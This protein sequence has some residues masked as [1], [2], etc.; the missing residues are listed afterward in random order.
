M[1]KRKLGRTDLHVS[2]LCLSAAHFG[3]GRDEAA[4]ALLDGYHAAGGGFV[5]CLG[6][7]ATAPGAPA[8]EG[9][10][11]DVVG[12]WRETR[13]VS[14]DSLVLASRVSFSRPAHGGTFALVNLV[15]ESCERSLRQLRTRHLDLLVCDWDEG[16][17]PVEDVLEAADMLIRAGLLRYAVAGAFP[18]WRLVDSLHRSATRHQPRF[19]ALQAEYSLLGRGPGER[20]ALAMCREHRL[21][22]LARSPLAGGFLGQRPGTGRDLLHPDRHWQ[23]E[24][25]GSHAG[26]AV[27][28]VLSEMADQRGV[29]PA[30]LAV[31]WVL[32]NAQVSSAVISPS[33]APEL[34]EL[35]G[36]SAFALAPEETAALAN[37]TTVQDSRMEL[38]H[39]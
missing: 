23:S 20:E 14:R 19:E 11:E 35:L 30:P 34:R 21:G 37:A 17:V 22:F 27:L 8:P 9:G 25:F 16:L 24:R 5:Q 2:E 7:P 29:T 6:T 39:L 18:A 15:R 36:A 3:S 38:R 10:S 1:N 13:A 32:E 4:F 31:A 12:R 26:D 33:T 28:R